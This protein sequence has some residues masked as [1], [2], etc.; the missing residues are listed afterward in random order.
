MLCVLLQCAAPLR[1]LA[2]D[3]RP[4]EMDSLPTARARHLRDIYTQLTKFEVDKATRRRI[5]ENLKLT[6]QVAHKLTHTKTKKQAHSA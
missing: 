6:V 1:W 3:G 5:L 4:V 2:A